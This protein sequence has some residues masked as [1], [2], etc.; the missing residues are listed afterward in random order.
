VHLK[1]N[2]SSTASTDLI[3][4]PALAGDDNVVTVIPGAEADALRLEV[5]AIPSGISRT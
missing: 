1:V 5:K 2:S 3:V 4:K